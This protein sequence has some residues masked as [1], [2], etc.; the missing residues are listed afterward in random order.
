[1]IQYS[2]AGGAPDDQWGAGSTNWIDQNAT[3]QEFHNIV[4]YE[5]CNYA[6][7]LAYYH[8]STMICDHWDNFNME[9]DS[10]VALG[11]K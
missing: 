6:S 5:P 9:M 2:D 8:V 11:K 1:M 7:N 3:M 4:I 10:V